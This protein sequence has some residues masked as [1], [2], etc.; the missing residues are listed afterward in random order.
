MNISPTVERPTLRLT[1]HSS[2]IAGVYVVS[3]HFFVYLFRSPAI[4]FPTFLIFFFLFLFLPSIGFFILSRCAIQS[5]FFCGFI[6]F[7]RCY[8]FYFKDIP[9][10]PNLLS[11]MYVKPSWIGLHCVIFFFNFIALIHPTWYVIYLLK[12]QSNRVNLMR[13]QSK[14]A[15]PPVL[16]PDIWKEETDLPECGIYAKISSKKLNEGK[17]IGRE[18][19]AAGVCHSSRDV[20]P[21]S[22]LEL[23]QCQTI[24]NSGR[25]HPGQIVYRQI[26]ETSFLIF[27]TICPLADD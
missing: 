23:A 26:K 3:R 12:F 6:S 11:I 27:Q 7:R 21:P 14:I 2:Y 24:F 25:I 22:R 4:G 20:C 5:S 17:E 19:V 9:E 10:I 15:S 1:L 8:R 16:L 18:R 13:W